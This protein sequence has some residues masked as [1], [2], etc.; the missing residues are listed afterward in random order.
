MATFKKL[1]KV[2]LN[3]QPVAKKAG[4]D[5]S[6][7]LWKQFGGSTILWYGA[8]SG[9]NFKTMEKLCSLFGCEPADLFEVKKLKGAD[10]E[11]WEAGHSSQRAYIPEGEAEPE[12]V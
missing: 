4:I 8:V 9:I 1:I 6:F 10:I 12:P 3:I 5:S 2:K 7:A 11:T